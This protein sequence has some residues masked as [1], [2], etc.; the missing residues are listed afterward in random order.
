MLYNS[1]EVHACVKKLLGEPGHSDRRVV[2]VA[3]IG[4]DG[5][6][7]LPHPENLHIICSPSPDATDPDTLRGLIRR[8]AKVQFSDG[9]HMKVYWSKHRGCLIASANA[10][11]SALGVNGLKEVGVL[12]PPGSVDIAR[13]M[14]YARAREINPRELRQLDTRTRQAR[15]SHQKKDA[16]SKIVPGYLDW[17][18]SP[19]RSPWKLS[20][21]GNAVSGNARASKSKSLA[22]YGVHEPHTWVS[23]AKGVKR[24]DWVL[25]F[26]SAPS[27]VKEIQWQFVDFLVQVGRNEKRFYFRNWPLHAVQVHPPGRYPLPPFGITPAFRVAFRN[28]ATRYSLDKLENAR[29]HTP[30]EKLL[31]YT[32]EFLSDR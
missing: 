29:T 7:Y 20:F 1:G 26:T 19:H 18:A 22:E 24:N 11:S 28:A 17:Y 21:W 16:R 27:G 5:E 15:K 23:V 12:L 13:L 31:R 6:S 4:T 9:L 10:S 30:P 3:Y 2:L 8:G 25:R 32:A 14:K